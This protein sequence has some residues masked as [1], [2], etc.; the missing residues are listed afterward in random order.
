MKKLLALLMAVSTCFCAFTACGNNNESE[1]EKSDKSTSSEKDDD[2]ES[3]DDKKDSDGNEDDTDKPEDGDIYSDK[4]MEMIDAVKAEDIPTVLRCSL[5]D[6]TMDA[7]ENT[8]SLDIMLDAMGSIS[9][10]GFD[11]ITYVETV[12]VEECDAEVVENL[13]KLYS[14]YSN[15]FFV[16]EKNDLTYAD[17]ESGNIDQDVAMELLEPATQLTQINDYANLDVDLSVEFE[18]AKMITFEYNN[19][20]EKAVAYKAVGEDWKIDT[21]GIQILRY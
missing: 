1:D 12:A 18:D 16:M 4:F 6:V 17:V 20:E 8:G 3:D 9:S 14:I 10:L 21:I 19:R 11:D 7:I 13:E 2:K 15:M 5:P